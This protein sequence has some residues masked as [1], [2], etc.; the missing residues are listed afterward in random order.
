MG[1]AVLEL[2]HVYLMRKDFDKAAAEYEQFSKDFPTDMR[3]QV[4]VQS[5]KIAEGKVDEGINGLEAIVAKTPKNLELRYQLAAYE[6][7]AGMQIASKDRTR[8]RQLYEDAAANYKQMLKTT[9]NSPEVWLRLGVLQRELGEYDAA[10]ASFQQANSADPHNSS[11]LLNAAMLLEEMGKK[12]EASATYTKVLGID[13]ENALAMNN[14]AFLNAEAGTNLDQAMT[15]AEKAKQKSPDS[16][17]IS[18]TLGYVYYQK[19]LNNQ[20]LQI[21]KELVAEHQDNPTFRLHL[22]MALEKSGE[23]GAARDEARKALQHATRPELQNQIK[24]F[25]SQ[26]G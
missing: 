11:A 9:A 25:L 10:L 8:A 19:H 3:G 12:K 5:V 23:K 2:G 18:D 16:P 13:P 14:L 26:L 21:F 24:T 22:A 7:Q 20:A 17:D 15:F 4:G 1:G 6:V